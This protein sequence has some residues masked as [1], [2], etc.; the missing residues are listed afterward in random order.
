MQREAPAARQPHRPSVSVQHRASASGKPAQQASAA[1]LSSAPR[2]FHIGGADKVSIKAQV[3]FDTCWRKLEESLKAAGKPMQA[4]DEV[5]WLNGAPGSGKGA[6]TPFICE[7]RGISRAITMSSLLDSSDEI[8]AIKDRGELVPD[9]MVGDALL[10]NI[11]DPS[12][13]DGSGILIDGFPRT[14][15]QV[16]FLKL[17]YDKLLELH[18]RH[19]DTPEE[20]HFPRPSFKV[21]VLYV[22]QQESVKRQM[23]RAQLAALHNTRAM[24]AGTDDQLREL[25]Q[26]DIDEAKCR[27]RYTVFKEHYGTLLRL[28]QHFPFSLID[29]MGPLDDC[30][31]QIQRELRYQSSMDLDEHTYAAIRH[32]PLAR[33]LVRLARQQLVHRLDSYMSRK[34]EPVFRRILAIIDAEVV[35]LLRKCSLAGHAEFKTRDEVFTDNEMAPDMLLDVLSDRGFSGSHII[36]E[37]IIPARVNPD[38]WEIVNHTDFIHKFRITFEKQGVRE[39]AA[40]PATASAAPEDAA[41][42]HTYLPSHLTPEAEHVAL[43][44]AL[45]AAAAGMLRP[46]KVTLADGLVV[47]KSPDAGDREATAAVVPPAQQEAYALPPQ[48]VQA[49]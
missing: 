17:L 33:D 11:F 3:V 31:R 42:G 4:P 18:L 32:L 21:V 28:K 38:T 22:D 10:N 19:A 34:N 5:V 35:P 13:A 37:R 44:P 26:T 45:A 29:A 48:R 36:N 8:K 43:K 24:D 9:T 16:D 49:A 14:A 6:N 46:E 47:E 15:M 20:R 41:I 27:A 7:S 39:I 30:R 25:R 12:V 1:E 40:G 23:A 2:S